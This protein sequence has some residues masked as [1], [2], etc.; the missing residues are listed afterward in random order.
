[1][2]RAARSP[3]PAVL[4][5]LVL[6]AAAGL[7]KPT[8]GAGGYVTADRTE[9][10]IPTG[11]LSS[12][13]LDLQLPDRS[14]DRGESGIRRARGP[15]FRPAAGPAVAL[16]LPRAVPQDAARSALARAGRLSSPAT[17]PPLLS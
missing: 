12:R 9:R 1:M 5:V 6:A 8:H 11:M 4:A 2:L 3:I 17:A 15:G 10:G 14:R 13:T 16:L 7:A